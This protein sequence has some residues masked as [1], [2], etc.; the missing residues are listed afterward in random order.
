MLSS[1]L[2]PLH[3]LS[4]SLATLLL[5]TPGHP[6]GADHLTFVCERVHVCV[7]VLVSRCVCT[8]A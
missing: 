7:C 3:I 1:G 8:Y 2:S 6:G 5:G 4:L